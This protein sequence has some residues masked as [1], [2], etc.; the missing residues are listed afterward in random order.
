MF[1]R[2]LATVV[3]AA[4]MLLLLLLAPPL[5]A[6]QQNRSQDQSKERDGP[7]RNE[8]GR[9][10]YIPLLT[11]DGR[12]RIRQLVLIETR[13]IHV[14][15]TS[16][17]ADGFGVDFENLDKIDVSD[18]PLIGSVM[19]R[20][21]SAEDFTDENR[22]GSV[23]DGG[24]GTLVTVLQDF[25]LELNTRVSVVNGDGRFTLLM[26]PRILET[27]P[28]DLS[29]FFALPSVRAALTQ[30]TLRDEATVV[31]GGLTEEKVPEAA[32]KLPWLSDIP[33]LQRLFRGTAHQGENSELLLFITP[34]I[35][36][37]SDS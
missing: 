2:A 31:L 10:S 36:T 22:V 16:G 30:V 11:A 25:T 14:V 1:Q 9:L 24:D 34:S 21:V 35:L 32:N 37:D 3:P 28:T 6:T 13:F 8:A 5:Q 23:Y 4:L 19:G 29:E 15:D 26:E 33:V 12:I 7:S 17:T 20:S 18:I 27:T